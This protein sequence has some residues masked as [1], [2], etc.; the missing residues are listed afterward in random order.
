MPYH[1]RIVSQFGT[2][3]G[4]LSWPEFPQAVGNDKWDIQVKAVQYYVSGCG[5]SVNVL[6]DQLGHEIFHLISN[7]RK[8]M[9]LDSS[10]YAWEH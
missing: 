5:L 1:I 10:E 9:F 8:V 4:L 6:C 3:L 7:F 2:L